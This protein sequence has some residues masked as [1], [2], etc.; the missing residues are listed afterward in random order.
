M[1]KKLR[2]IE[3]ICVAGIA[4]LSA[5]VL[6]GIAR[7]YRTEPPAPTQAPDAETS[8]TAWVGYLPDGICYGQKL[9][10]T[11]FRAGDGST[12]DLNDWAGKKLLLLFWG[13][14][15]PYCDEVL[16]QWEA[17]ETVLSEHPDYELVL[18]NKLDPDR[19]ETV[20]GAQAYLSK[21]GV[22]FACLYDE[23]LTA[24]RAYG[25]K[26]IPTLLLLDGQGYLRYMTADAPRSAPELQALLAYAES[27]GAAATERFL[28]ERMTGA[29]GGVFTTLIDRKG[30]APTGHDVLSESQGLL[31]EY[32]VHARNPALFEQS[33][34]YA[35]DWLRREGVF[36]WYATEEGKQADANALIDDLRLYRALKAAQTLWGG[37][38]TE[39]E[40]L[41]QALLTHNVSDGQPVG[42]YDFRQRR[43]GGTIPLCDLDMEALQDLGLRPQAEDILRGGYISD[44]FPLYHSSYDIASRTYSADSLNTSEALMAL[45]QAVKAG[46]AR[47]ASLEWLEDKVVAGTLAARYEVSGQAVKGFDYHS[48][49]AYAIAAL[50]GAQSGNARLYTF[51]RHRMEAYYVT[52]S[53]DLQGSFS[54]RADGSDII[55]FDQLMPLL[56]YASTKDITFDD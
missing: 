20:E 27:G 48:T 18:I 34:Q 5:V 40:A 4:V 21:E 46:L 55:A 10:V 30:A 25:V 22:P 47:Q 33:W 41:A 53:S 6:L 51:A 49:A 28:T 7:L 38:E 12:R 42:F 16:Q 3:R 50:I 23:G 9:P 39:I 43:A 1:E 13:S 36:A 52:E 54:N 44:A 26:R 17:Y 31:M 37:F 8:L 35:R 24:C 2:I 56:V 15:C 14:W 29:E 11:A 45:Y 32:A 19:G